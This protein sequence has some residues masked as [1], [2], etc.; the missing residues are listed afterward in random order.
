MN[1]EDTN[2]CSLLAALRRHYPDP[3]TY[4]TRVCTLPRSSLQPPGFR[5]CQQ[6]YPDDG[7]G[8]TDNAGQQ[9]ARAAR[10]RLLEQPDT[11]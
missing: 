8:K 11:K 6:H 2:V 1:E 9:A 4:P 3:V 10:N 7:D 5:G